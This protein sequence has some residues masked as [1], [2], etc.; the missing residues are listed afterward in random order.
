[1]RLVEQLITVTGTNP[2][3]IPAI[4]V[5]GQIAFVQRGTAS[6]AEDFTIEGILEPRLYG[7]FGIYSRRLWWAARRLWQS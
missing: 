7:R 6:L 5:A 4:R 2:A 3:V 1:M